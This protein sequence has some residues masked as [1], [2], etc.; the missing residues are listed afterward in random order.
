MSRPYAMY[1]CVDPDD[2]EPCRRGEHDQCSLDGDP[3]CRCATCPPEHKAVMRV[4]LD[5]N[6]GGRSPWK[7]QGGST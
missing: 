1:I 2:C 5:A 4:W 3:D 6:I 7:D